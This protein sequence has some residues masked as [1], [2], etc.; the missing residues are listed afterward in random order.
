MI[1]V[2]DIAPDF[3]LINQ[4]RENVNLSDYKGEAVVL[5]FYPGAFQGDV[6]R[7]CVL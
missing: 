6:R 5:A 2:G 7:R 3:T 1:E 4:D